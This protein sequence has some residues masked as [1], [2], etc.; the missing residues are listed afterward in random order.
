MTLPANAYGFE[1]ATATPAYSFQLF[2]VTS[3]TFTDAYEATTIELLDRGRRT[4]YGT[5]WGM[6]GTLTAKMFDQ[7]GW[8]ARQQRLDLQ[9]LKA[10]RI[11]VLMQTPF[12]D[13]IKVNLGDIQFDR[14]AGVGTVEYMTV[15]IPYTEVA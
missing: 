12:G 4:E 2:N 14:V 3:D 9:D 6:T 13:I 15:T 1:D 7:P 8:T 11:S 5:H 10:R